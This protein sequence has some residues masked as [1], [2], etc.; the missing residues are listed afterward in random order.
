MKKLLLLTGLVFSGG[1]L[2]HTQSPGYIEDNFVYKELNTYSFTVTNR[3]TELS[4]FK[5]IVGDY[6]N[7]TL[8]NEKTVGTIKDIVKGEGVKFSVS[9]KVKP[10]ESKV[11]LVCTEA[12]PKNK[13]LLKSRICSKVTMERR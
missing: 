8:L 4:D 10:S 7:K 3:T 1:V 11:K 6:E 2:S 12:S 5:V 13:L 9:F